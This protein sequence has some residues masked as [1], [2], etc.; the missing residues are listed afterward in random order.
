MQE[1]DLIKYIKGETNSQEKRRIIEWIRKDYN[2]QKL[3]NNL[4]AEYVASTFDNSD[5]IDIEKKYQIFCSK[6][7]KKQKYQYTGIV[8]VLLIPLIAWQL[9]TYFSYNPIVNDPV[10]IS[11]YS[12][13]INISTKSGGKKKVTL[14]D[15]SVITLNAESKLSYPNR[16]S[17]STRSVTLI[18]EAF[19]DIKRDIAKPFIVHTDDLKVKV[20]G[21]S[22]NIKSYPDD[23]KIET[24]L[25]TG[26]VELLQ[27]KIEEPI[28][29]E[30]S[31]RATFNKEK[32]NI[33]IE[34]VNSRNII[35]WKQGKLIFNQ[36][37]LKQVVLDLNRKYGADFI[38]KSD[39]LLQ[40]KY[41]GVFNN[42]Q[43][44]EEVL[45]ILKLSSRINYKYLN[46]KVML[47]SQ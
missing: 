39:T 46:N 38:I 36:T 15:G 2:N 45:E 16:F 14:P 24:T 27:E 7:I 44:L 6:K 18:G 26:K 35:A 31:H 19:F 1:K 13:I 29:L 11:E 40:Y 33:K 30:P 32:S 41:T 5:H 43:S 10:K 21:T 34:K 37:P 17:D 20:L 28:V 47:E 42:N 4:K 12:S 23:E 25:V 8:A 9:Y 3:Y 22:F